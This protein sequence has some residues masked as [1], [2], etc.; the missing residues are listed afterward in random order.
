MVYLAIVVYILQGDGGIHANVGHIHLT[1]F[2]SMFTR[3]WIHNNKI[4]N[5]YTD[6]W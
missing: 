6:I 5:L 1:R 3:F 4:P 2:L